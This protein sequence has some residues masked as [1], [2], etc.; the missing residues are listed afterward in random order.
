ME[1][2]NVIPMQLRTVL[3]RL[4]KNV[5]SPIPRSR[6][7]VAGKVVKGAEFYAINGIELARRI[8]NRENGYRGK[9]LIGWQDGTV[10]QL[11]VNGSYMGN[12]VEEY[13]MGR[14][15]E[16]GVWDFDHAYNRLA[17]MALPQAA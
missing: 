15:C 13:R 1:R 7:L 9:I 3:T 16:P 17:E 5:F 8:T 14:A 12:E 6:H 4:P 11:E 2:N 10:C